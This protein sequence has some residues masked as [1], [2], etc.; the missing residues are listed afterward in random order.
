M[1]HAFHGFLGSPSD[2]AFLG[3][4]ARLHTLHEVNVASLAQDLGPEDILIGYSM[5]GRIALELAAATDFKIKQLVLINAHP[6]LATAEEKRARQKWEDE[7]L[8]RL[9]QGPEEFFNYWNALPIFAADGPLRPIEDM[10]GAAKLFDRFRLS[11]Q[12]NFLPF[13]QHH[14]HKVLVLIGEQD[15]KYRQMALERLLPAGIRYRLLKGGHRLFQRPA[16]VL[17]VLKEEKVL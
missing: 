8:K 10:A 4:E 14:R 17:S 7:I 13:I 9:Q 1:I 6:G 11:R 12:E 16:E 2:L 15:E 5:G 3:T